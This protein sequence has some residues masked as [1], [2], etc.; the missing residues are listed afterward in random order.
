MTGERTETDLCVIG[1][2]SGGLTVAAGASQMG[3]RVVLIEKGKM[4]GDSLNTGCVPSKALIAAAER[5]HLAAGGGA[6]GI[7]CQAVEV[8]YKAVHDHVQGVIA[9]IAP[10]D[11]EA[12]FRDL[13][14]T[15]IKGHARFT[16]R[17]QVTVGEQTIRA[18]RFVIASGSSPAIPP[19]DGLDKVPYLTNETIF[20][21]DDRPHSLMVIGGGPIG[22]E[23]AQAMARLGVSVTVL[24]K[25]SFLPRDDP[26]A[27]AVVLESLRQ[28]GV[29]LLDAVDI[30]GLTGDRAAIR[31]SGQRKGQPL[32]LAA[33][34]LLVA[35]G[36][37]PNVDDLGLERAG[38]DFS[39][40]GIAVDRKLRTGNRRVFAIGDVTGG[41]QFTHVAAA[42]AGIVLR[43]ALFPFS[44]R[45]GGKAVPWVTY[46]DPE[47]AHVG[48]TEA[49]AREKGGPVRVLRWPLADND[50]AQAERR[51]DGLIKVVTGRRGRILG[52]TIA[53][54]GAG[55]LIL[56][57]VLAIDA[58]LGIGAMAGVIAPYP[59]VAE[60][61]KRVAGSYYTPAL[62]APPMRRL[63]RLL[64]RLP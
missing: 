61:S 20:D 10:N 52:A 1:A 32:S 9:A 30:E 60:I 50:R 3:A 22:L 63:V 64:M 5:A 49:A 8:D 17:R 19:I 46:T 56:P 51:T 34:H 48:L 14:V 33:S 18:R 35:T 58:G 53:A 59:T 47:L 11:S 57:W 31:V 39:P 15:V 23:I 27:A 2:G 62:F 13:G 25:F 12:R 42:E 45:S 16:G 28:D 24:E 40:R 29:K 4:G 21:L 37:R 26:E 55:E 36:R 6:F 44:T 7:R 54:A 38:I 41:L 43:N